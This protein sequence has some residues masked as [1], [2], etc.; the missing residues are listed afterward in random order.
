[1]S[2]RKQYDTD[3]E[4]LKK[5][6]TEMGRNSADAVENVLEAL[7]VADA[8]AAAAIVKGDA[9]INNMER[10]IEHRCMTLLLRQ[11]PVAGDLRRISTAMKVVTD[12]ER[13]GDHAADI[14]EIIPHLVTVRKEG[15][16]AVSQAIAM[17]KKAHQ[18]ILDALAALMAE[19]ELAARKVIAADDAVDYDFNAIKHQLAQEIAEDPG[20]VDAAL[21]L[22]MVIKYLER[23]GDHAVNVAEWVQFV[24]TGCYKDES[25]F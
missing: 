20:K 8:D 12:I 3:L 2:I 15:D 9:R 16:P 14:A 19:D 7:C 17:G 5:S 13:I 24:R 25:M 11:Q 4:S 21:D 22:L 1:M 10:D 6:L 18:M 23:I